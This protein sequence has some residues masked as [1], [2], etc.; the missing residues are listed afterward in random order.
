M[1]AARMS[2][3]RSPIMIAF[4]IDRSRRR[5]ARRASPCRRGAPRD[6]RRRCPEVLREAEQRDDASREDL[7]LRRAHVDRR[8]ARR[9]RP[10]PRSMPSYT[11]FSRQPTSRVPLAV[12]RDR[13]AR[14]SPRRGCRAA[15][16]TISRSGG[17]TQRRSAASSGAA[18]P[19]RSSAC[20]D[21]ARDPRI[22][23][24]QRA[25][26]IEQQSAPCVRH[27]RGAQEPDAEVD[28]ARPAGRLPS[29]GSS[30]ARSVAWKTP[31]YS[32]HVVAGHRSQT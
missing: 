30:A 29:A 2:C 26:E 14:S 25:V 28:A 24:G 11:T 20:S 21:R 6:R 7:G 22:V 18:L 12:Q 16:R 31:A 19:I 1:R 5:C 23:V 8:P 17:P 10:P 3:A 15:T 27:D 32:R 9:A 13:T 4:R